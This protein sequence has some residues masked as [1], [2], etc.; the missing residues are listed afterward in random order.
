MRDQ[1]RGI[2]DS[3]HSLPASGPP[4][5]STIAWFFQ[6]LRST[7]MA[8]IFLGGV[9]RAPPEFFPLLMQAHLLVRVGRRGLGPDP[10]PARR[11][12][13]LCRARWGGGCMGAGAVTPHRAERGDRLDR[14][15]GRR[16]GLSGPARPGP[17]RTRAARVTRMT[18][19]AGIG[20]AIPP[21]QARALSEQAWYRRSGQ[22]GPG[23]RRGPV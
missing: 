14:S 7:R 8:P 2:F 17:A 1:Q 5:S 12:R 6:A 19:M 4:Q 18:R 16:P 9:K 10:R 22:T 15:R 13:R 21:A 23:I 3:A 20:R 11:G